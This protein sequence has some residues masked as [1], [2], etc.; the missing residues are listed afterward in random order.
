MDI[1]KDI[2][3]LISCAV[4]KVEA[5]EIRCKNINFEELYRLAYKHNCVTIIYPA[6]KNLKN[7]N[8]EPWETQLYY[9]CRKNLMFEKERAKIFKFMDKNKIWHMPLKGIVLQEL[10]PQ[11]GMR[12]MVDNDILFDKNF[13]SQVNDF[14]AAD[15]YEIKPGNMHNEFNKKPLYNFELHKTLCGKWPSEKFYDYFTN[16]DVLLGEGNLKH[17]SNENFYLYQTTHAYRH[18]LASGIGLRQLIDTYVVL[19]NLDINLDY[20]EKTCKQ[21]DVYEFERNLRNLS[22]KLFKDPHRIP[23]LNDAENKQFIVY[24]KSSTTGTLEEHVGHKLEKYTKDPKTFFSFFFPSFET[25]Q[26]RGLCYVKHKAFL[27]VYWLRWYYNKFK[28]QSL[29]SYIRAAKKYRKNK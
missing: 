28:Y 21:L 26:N 6:I 22:M 8:I 7:V 1:A 5:D 29:L 3:Y 18:D 17:L 25:M 16:D 4:N 9:S 27:P 19:N 23:K 15:K 12:Q 13:E 2:V 24:L 20:V 11:Y 14:M 10:Y